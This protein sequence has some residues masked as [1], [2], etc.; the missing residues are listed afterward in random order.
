MTKKQKNSTF[1]RKKKNLEDIPDPK[2]LD[3]PNICF[4]LTN[5]DDKREKV[6]SKQRKRRGFDDSETWSLR[7]TIAN[8]TL[9][10]LERYLEV[11]EEI[12]NLDDYRDDI[13][14]FKTALELISRDKGSCIWTKKEEKQVKKGLEAFP[15]IFIA[16]WW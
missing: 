10:R 8:F 5:K 7:D 15:K 3:I 12:I 6:F 16:L 1:K 14:K 4:S 2:Y 11:A 13:N 9:P